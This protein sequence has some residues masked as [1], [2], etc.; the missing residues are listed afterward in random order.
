MESKFSSF[1]LGVF[2]DSSADK[3]YIYCKIDYK[4]RILHLFNLHL[5]ASYLTSDQSSYHK[6]L[7]LAA[8]SHQVKILKKEVTALLE[9]HC[10]EKDLVLLIG[11]FNINAHD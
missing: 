8:R 9:K 2:S 5:Q 3:G 11:D 1:G 4:G 10:E 7:S 6:E